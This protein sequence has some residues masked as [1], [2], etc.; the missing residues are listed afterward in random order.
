[1]PP[2]DPWVLPGGEVSAGRGQQKVLVRKP[3]EGTEPAGKQA[4]LEVPHGWE[5]RQ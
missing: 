2:G 5:A 1:M 4:D 3:A